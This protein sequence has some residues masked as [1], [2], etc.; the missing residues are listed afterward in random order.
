[1]TLF[2]DATYRQAYDLVSPELISWEFYNKFTKIEPPFGSLGLIVY[3]RTYSRYIESLGRREK[4][5]ETILRVVE[6]SLSL[7][8]ITPKDKKVVEAERLFE[9]LFNLDCFAAGR[10]YWVAGTAQTKK[11]SSSNWNCV[12]R[13][14]DDL[15]SFT[16]L[17]YWLLIGA[18]T[19]FSVEK[20]NIEKL[21]KMYPGN[22]KLLH[23]DYD[24]VDSKEEDTTVTFFAK[25]IDYAPYT[26]DLEANY[27]A[28]SDKDFFDKVTKHGL[29]KEIGDA[30][31]TIGDSKE[32]WCNALRLYLQLLTLPKPLNILFNY[33]AVRPKGQRIKIF[34]GRSSGYQNI[35]E[36]IELIHNELLL[37]E[38]EFTSVLALTIM[39]IIG[40]AVVS[41]GVRR[42]AE[43][44]LGDK[45]DIAFIEAKYGL[46]EK[47]ELE[48]YR[49]IRDKSNNSVMYYERP[50][51]EE[52]R[53]VLERARHNGEPGLC[54]IGNAQ[55][56]DSGISGFNP[57]LT[58][59]TLVLTK[60]GHYPIRELVGKEVTV[61][62]G[63]SWLTVN[64]FRVTGYNQP[65]YSVELENG[66]VINATEYHEFVLEDGT[67]KQLKHLKV[68][69]QLKSHNVEFQGNPSDY[70]IK[71]IKFNYVADKV[72]CCT[73]GT[74]HNFALS[75]N[76]LI[77]QCFESGL[78]SS[79]SCNLVTNNAAS[80]V[81]TTLVEG[82]EIKLFNWIKWY[83]ILELSTR[84]ACRQTTADQW[85]PEWDKVQKSQR[86]LGVS[87]TGIMDVYDALNWTNDDLVGFFAF[88]KQV[89]REVADKYH[90]ELG[91]ER[92]AR[93]SLIK[94][95]GTLSKLAG[96]SEGIHRAYAPQFINRIR[97][98][99]NDPLA[100]VLYASGV[101]VVPE[102]GQGD[103]LYGEK[104]NT[105]VFSF[106][107]TSPTK[108][109]YIDEP[110]LDQMER[111][112]IV[113]KNFVDG[114]HNCSITI[115]TA[116][117]EWEDAYKWVYDNWEDVIAVSFLGRF[118][119]SEGEVGAYPNMP[120]ETCTPEQH[121]ELAAKI[122]ALSEEALL[123]KLSLVE[124][125]YDEFALDSDCAGGSCPL[126]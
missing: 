84:I 106:P 36:C 112:K 109:R 118:D 91:I 111:Y 32:G 52:L 12:F 86:L 40:R 39:N 51:L 82:K 92:S 107:A 30:C 74:T 56:H 31:I 63:Y 22:K 57:C 24:Y 53:S 59:D 2:T 78:R 15:S 88:S 94:P 76:V 117:D 9:A 38:G 66:Q 3:L 98:A 61:W 54:A 4:W 120:K 96:V 77:G 99:S 13:N 125:E 28:L 110:A 97:F 58:G 62:D 100:Q 65:V 23:D 6:Y 35:K 72:Y 102:N 103:D 33:D 8:K 14:L 108:V 11:D 1:M 105:W 42:T 85:H 25:P 101:P 21:P 73:V 95:E 48:R 67:K 45:D 64:N 114:G 71:S 116:E 89:T 83:E 41:G 80:C 43:D 37:Y 113:Q 7:D 10:S 79:Q 121:Q 60:E 124:G 17:F 29:P 93:V 90:Q 19:G 20:K 68:G 122:P 119:P 34:G 50:S 115:S 69:E 104:C 87:I 126:R 18:G 26:I 44:G 81:M 5:C 27:L 49:N 123:E 55:K 75:N 47:P 16:E 70:V 46:W